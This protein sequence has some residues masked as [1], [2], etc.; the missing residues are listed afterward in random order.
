[1]KER[2]CVFVLALLAVAAVRAQNAFVPNAGQWNDRV[3]YRTDVRSGNAFLENDRITF[4]FYNAQE[5]S[6]IHDQLDTLKDAERQH[7]IASQKIH[8]YAYE[9]RFE[10]S[11]AAGVSGTEKQPATASYFIGN[12]ET[13]WKG[14]LAMYSGVA[15]DA[16]YP[17]IDLVFHNKVSAL[18]YDFIVEAGADA[19][20]IRMTYSGQ[21]SLV[22]RNGALEIGADFLTVRE[23]IPAAFQFVD[24][25]QVK[26]KCE[27]Y[28]SGTA[29]SFRFPDGYDTSKE[30]IIDPEVVASTHSGGTAMAFGFTSTYDD[31]GNIYVGGVVY[32]QGYPVTLGA[33]DVTYAGMHDIGISKFDPAG[34]ALIYCTYVGGTDE[35]Y[36]MSTFVHQGNLYVYGCANSS[37]FP[38]TAGAFD[39][40]YAGMKDIIVFCLNSNATALIGSTY[41]GGTGDDGVNY[42]NV[43]LGDG[44]RGEI[45]VDAGGNVYVVSG[46]ASQGFP[47]T[48]GA[49]STAYSG[50]VDAVIFKMNASL[51]TMLW[52]TFLGASLHDS[53]M[54]IRVDEGGYVYVC[55][56][57]RGIFAGFPVVSGCY[58]TTYGGGSSDAYVAKFDPT[59]SNL[60][61]CTYFGGAGQDMGYFID[62]D[63]DGDVYITGIYPQDAPV[64]NGVYANPGSSNFI[65]KFNSTLTTLLLSTVIGDG[66]A[67]AKVIPSAFMVD[68]CKRI[69]IG[70]FGGSQ[71]W[72]LTNDALFTTWDQHTQWYLAS[73]DENAT[74]LLFGTLYG[75]WHCDG[76]TSRFD[77]D[78]I[79][80]QAVCADS[81]EFPVT[82]WAYADGTNT[83][84][85]DICVFKIDF[86]IERDT[87][88]LP[89]VFTPN[90]DGINDVYDVSL[91]TAHLYELRI[92]D[93]W[94]IVVFST[95]DLS[96][97]WDGTYDGRECEEGVYYVSVKHGYCAEE[98]YVNTG[99]MHLSRSQRN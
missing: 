50:G 2:C 69:Y 78:G 7:E 4:S 66:T 20:Q 44:Y 45:V 70:G 54:S 97:K 67:T 49:F 75:S 18:K 29:V 9:V 21:R 91:S 17:G 26:V 89:N 87:L 42:I 3:L 31:A 33:Y 30:L 16:L 72:P 43:A 1:M 13:R 95:N 11:A 68:K 37:D 73:L 23:I 62:L 82:P 38:V 84:L 12:D 39:Q 8:C 36:P 86:E 48:P 51:T 53:G 34:S 5:I 80:Y 14:G 63:T 46:S 19:S 76:G 90:G 60:V 47:V 27:Y 25:K 58:Q 40:T 81:A 55:G 10:N 6:A 77:P 94:G 41:V 85:W 22:L 88:L 56:T 64:T 65:A 28:L 92:Y 83:T 98:P 59:G 96:A 15:Y 93:R 57:V 74:S 99:F 61:A 79:V 52:A 24:G 71:G 32:S 35:E